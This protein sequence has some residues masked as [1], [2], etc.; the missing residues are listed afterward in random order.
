MAVDK[1]NCWVQDENG[2]FWWPYCVVDGCE[3]RV[4]VNISDRF[5]FPHSPGNPHVNRMKIAARNGTP[6]EELELTPE[7]VN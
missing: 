6:I 2:T 4:C 1:T 3:N 7:P 5:C